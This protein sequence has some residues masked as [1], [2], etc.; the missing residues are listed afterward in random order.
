MTPTLEKKDIVDDEI[1]DYG[2]DAKILIVD[3][4]VFNLQTIKMMLQRTFKL[5][6]SVF[7]FCANNGQEALNFVEEDIKNFGRNRFK[8]ILM[9]CQ[10][11]VM[12]GYEASRQIR[13]ITS[14]DP[15]RIVAITGH[16]EQKY[17]NLALKAGMD[18]LYQKPLAIVNLG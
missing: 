2:C 17:K 3:D 15:P 9:D 4:A 1:S 6:Q 13:K 7:N 14:A 10:M 12:D 8:L 18:E 5:D 16:T 11:P